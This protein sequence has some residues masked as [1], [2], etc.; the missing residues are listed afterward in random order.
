MSTSRIIQLAQLIASETHTLDE[1]LNEN[2]LPQPS[3]AAGAPTEPFPQPSPSV[4]KARTNVIEATI[5]LRQLLE[6]PVKQLLPESNFAPLASVYRFN[7]AKHVPVGGTISFSDLAVKCKLLEHDLKRIIRH[8]S[9]HHRVFVE[10]DE[11]LVAHTAASR[12]LVDNE[13]IGDLM[14]LTF[15]ECWPAHARAPDAIA[16]RSEEPNISGYSLANN[17]D[18]NMFQYLAEHPDRARRFA[19]AMSSTSPASLDALASHL[20]WAAFPPGTT[21]VDVGGAQ[22]HVS[23]HL[24][25]RFP[26]LNFVVQDIPEVIDGAEGKVPEELGSRVSLVPH[27]MF[28]PQPARNA[29]VY[30][31]RYVLHDWPDKYCI[32]VIENIVPVLKKGGKIVLQEHVLAE[33]G[34]LG[35]LAE[36]QVRSMDAIMM[37]LFNS[38]ERTVA[39]WED[40]FAR[41]GKGG[42]DVSV[43]RV[44]GNA[45]TGVVVAEWRG[46]A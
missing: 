7:I 9:I 35:L 33:H 45:A 36:M 2:K 40:V 5:E 3:F 41:A 10:P 1:H 17:T 15:A 13:L 6:G 24:A 12:L 46:S 37:S 30:L 31:L 39:D 26:G 4:T 43:K 8:T 19:G 42:F 21:V 27:D 16:H 28:S 22:G 20:D 25:R 14:G 44:E 32:R 18:L 23:V 11:G 29:D 38:R 34:S